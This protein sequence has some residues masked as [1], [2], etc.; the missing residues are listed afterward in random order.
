LKH[1]RRTPGWPFAC[2]AAQ[3]AADP[4]NSRFYLWDGP[5]TLS[6][7]ASLQGGSAD[8]AFL[9]AQ[10]TATASILQPD[11]NL[12]L[13]TAMLHIGYRHVVAIGGAVTDK[14]AARIALLFGTWHIGTSAA[15]SV[16]IIAERIIPAMLRTGKEGGIMTDFSRFSDIERRIAN[17]AYVYGLSDA[18][19]EV[20]DIITNC[21]ETREEIEQAASD[22]NQALGKVAI[23]A[24]HLVDYYAFRNAGNANP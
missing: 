6:D 11:E 2:L 1:S 9:S 23:T 22:I 20:R 15:C 5:L 21:G 19:N 18:N 7:I 16:Y 10:E 17:F 3:D 14:E 13:A 8:L 12:N 24:G 4:A